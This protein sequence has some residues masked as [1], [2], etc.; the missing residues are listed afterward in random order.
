[1]RN[2]LSLWNRNNQPRSIFDWPLH[3]DFDSFFTPVLANEEQRSF[4]PACEVKELKDSF[5]IALDVPGVAKEDIKVEVEKGM[6]K[7]SGHRK[8]ETKS[9]D[10]GVIRNERV[11]GEFT[12]SFTLP[13]T[14]DAEKIQAVHRDGVLKISVPK[15]EKEKP[16]LID[17]KIA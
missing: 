12:R 14:V 8:S 11:F 7:I 13:E 2:A 3:G 16:K 5:S 1:M 6:L 4:V 9:E 17:V 10:D 15:S